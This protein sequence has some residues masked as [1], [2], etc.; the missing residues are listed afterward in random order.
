MH[1]TYRACYTRAGSID[2]LFLVMTLITWAVLV[3]FHDIA[4]F[5]WG[6]VLAFTACVAVIVHQQRIKFLMGFIN[7]E[8]VFR[9]QSDA[10]ASLLK[11]SELGTAEMSAMFKKIALTACAEL[12]L[13]RFSIWRLNDEPAS[14]LCTF[15]YHQ[16][17]AEDEKRNVIFRGEASKYFDALLEGRT[18]A[19]NNARTD[20]R[21]I[22]LLVYFKANSIPATLD[23]PIIVNGRLYGVVCLE[24]IQR[25]RSRTI[26]DQ[27]FAASLADIVALA[28]SAGEQAK[29]LAQQMLAYSGRS[30]FL[31]KSRDI[32]GIAREF[33]SF[34]GSELIG[35]M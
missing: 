32:S 7:R 1:C 17:V 2:M 29:E 16:M 11:S 28:I 10:L 35:E 27:N 24:E 33:D 31:M 15:F 23:E 14:I 6:W 9:R 18:I 3:R 5:Q 4:M 34:W 20:S 12:E 26:D 19:A 25:T 22:C 13:G 21:T 8:T 30:N